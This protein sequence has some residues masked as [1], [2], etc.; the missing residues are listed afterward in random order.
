MYPKIY[1]KYLIARADSDSSWTELVSKLGLTKDDITQITELIEKGRD[2]LI[3]TEYDYVTTTYQIYDGSPTYVWES[4]LI[5]NIR[6][7]EPFKSL[8]YST[9]TYAGEK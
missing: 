6:E 2:S 3:E 8:D 5:K 1:R 9:E 4:E 7:A